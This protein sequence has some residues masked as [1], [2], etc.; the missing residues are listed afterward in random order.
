MRDAALAYVGAVVLFL[1]WLPNFIYQSTHTGAPWAPPPRFG[2]PVL[3]S[4]DLIGGDR[5]TIGAGARGGD[6]LRAAVHARLP[7]HA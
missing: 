4:R 6:R 7:A 2:A 1:P 5:I 3:I